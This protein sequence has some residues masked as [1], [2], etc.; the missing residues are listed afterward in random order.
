MHIT[1]AARLLGGAKRIAG[2]FVDSSLPALGVGE[3]LSQGTAEGTLQ[4]RALDAFAENPGS[5]H[6]G[7]LTVVWN[8]SSRGINATGLY[9]DPYFFLCVYS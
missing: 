5:V 8:S 3:T 7:Q 9:G 4:G 6:V 1:V 2:G